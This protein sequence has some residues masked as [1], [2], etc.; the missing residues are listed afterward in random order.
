MGTWHIYI[1]PEGGML[2]S[3]NYSVPS[4]Q[5]YSFICSCLYF[6]VNTRWM[7]L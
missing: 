3:L 4:C 1:F 2:L 7:V 6:Y 5:L